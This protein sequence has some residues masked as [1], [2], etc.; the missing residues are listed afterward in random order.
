MTPA[1]RAASEADI[2]FIAE[3]EEIA[4][5]PPFPHSMWTPILEPTGTGLRP[6]LVAMYETGASRW[7]SV[8]DFRVLM[9]GAE[10]VA[11][12][13][14]YAPEP[15]DPD[16]RSLRLD[17]LP[18]LG[19]RLSWT[20]A[21]V[22]AFRSAYDA[23]WGEP[24]DWLKPQATAILETVGVRPGARGTGLGRA[25]VADAI[26]QA[27]TCGHGHLGVSFVLG[28]ARGQRLYEAMGF[29]PV[30][31]FHAAF[32][33]GTFPGFARYRRRLEPLS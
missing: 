13:M 27:T 32:F 16:P 2:P 19:A 17:R 21:T 24:G 29:E 22:A 28:N 20:R 31:T 1:F 7:G 18:E 26:R 8:A 15:D 3:I 5:T 10:P 11:G 23:A 4:S 30:V 6:F 12:C 25:L 14:V 9:Q 33:E